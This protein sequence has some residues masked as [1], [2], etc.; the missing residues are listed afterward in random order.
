V[1][2]GLHVEIRIDRANAIGRP[3]AAGVADVV[4]ES[5]ITTIMDCEDSVAAVDA[6]DKALA[7]RNW[8]GLMRGDL[9]ERSEGRQTFDPRAEPRPR[10]RAPDGSSRTLLKGRSLM[11]VRN[12]GHLMT[13]PPCSTATGNEAP[14]ACWTRC[15]RC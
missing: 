12:V 9:V 1:H 4:L 2:H 8:L 5:A 13:N 14:K 3:T 6:E 11:L 15:A 10:L 7:Y